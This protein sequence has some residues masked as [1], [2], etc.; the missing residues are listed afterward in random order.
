MVIAS[1]DVDNLCQKIV[2]IWSRVLLTAQMNK[3]RKPTNIGWDGVRFGNNLFLTTQASRKTIFLF[4]IAHA[5]YPFGVG[6]IFHNDFIA[7]N[8]VVTY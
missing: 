1:H 4:S 2:V 3:P 7:K 5:M 6:A 8:H